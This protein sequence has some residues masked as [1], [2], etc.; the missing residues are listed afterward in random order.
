[1]Q[2]Q[3]YRGENLG[4]EK[5]EPFGCSLSHSDCRDSILWCLS[6]CAAYRIC[7]IALWTYKFLSAMYFCTQCAI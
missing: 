3:I 7:F 4:T 1:M 2:V 6:Q 5:K